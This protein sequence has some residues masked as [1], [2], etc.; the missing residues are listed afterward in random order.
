MNV[1]NR[2][3]TEEIHKFLGMWKKYYT[4]SSKLHVSFN[5]HIYI[6]LRNIY[7]HSNASLITVIYSIHCYFFGRVLCV[8]KCCGIEMAQQYLK[9]S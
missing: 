2:E 1:L 4:S 8:Q 5:I 3:G 9:N 7:D 6:I